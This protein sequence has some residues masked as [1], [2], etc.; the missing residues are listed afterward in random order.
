[1][2]FLLL[3][4]AFTLGCGA[5]DAPPEQCDQPLPPADEDGVPWPTYSA[6]QTRLADCAQ[7]PGYSRRRGTCSDGKVLLDREGG[8][9]GETY[10]FQG[11]AVVGLKRTPDDAVSCMEYRFGDTRCDGAEIEPIDCP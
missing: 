11:E 8:G 3:L 1:M 6:A 4:L 5:A 2:K 9:G 10:Y 7:S